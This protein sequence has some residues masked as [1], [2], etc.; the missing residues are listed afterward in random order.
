MS[1]SGRQ[2][3]LRIAP[4][5][6]LV[7]GALVKSDMLMTA[8]TAAITPSTDLVDLEDFIQE[9]LSDSSTTVR[10]T[11]REPLPEIFSL[12]DY[13]IVVKAGW[14]SLSYRNVAVG[15]LRAG[16]VFLES[17]LQKSFETGPRSAIAALTTAELLLVKRDAFLSAIEDRP[18]VLRAMYALEC[19]RNMEM[20]IRAARQRTE[21]LENQLA[22]F[23]WDLGSP[24]PSGDRIVPNLNQAIVADCLGIRREA[25]NRKHKV[26]VERGLMSKPGSDWII[27]AKVGEASMAVGYA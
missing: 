9:T 22:Y 6:L 23:L 21:D 4:S 3:F 2:R 18:D 8:V 5:A 24:T 17:V 16:E 1:L 10:L 13:V 25:I 14:V 20:C 15:M 19:S 11:K 26:L 27:S 7:I 12:A